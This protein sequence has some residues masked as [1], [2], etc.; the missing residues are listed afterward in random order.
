MR[1]DQA[2]AIRDLLARADD[3]GDQAVKNGCLILAIG[4]LLEIIE[5]QARE[6]AELRDDLT[7]TGTTAAAIRARLAGR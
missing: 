6:L 7:D 2:D 3:A 5:A 4:Q 1:Y